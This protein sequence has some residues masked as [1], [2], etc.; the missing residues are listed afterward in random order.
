MFVSLEGLNGQLKLV[1]TVY[2]S[3]IPGDVGDITCL[4][5]L[6]LAL[7]EDLVF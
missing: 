7:I 5:F 6:M 2:L 4:I 3:V 1:V